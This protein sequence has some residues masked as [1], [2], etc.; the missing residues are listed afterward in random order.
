MALLCATLEGDSH[1]SCVTAAH[2]LCLQ[3]LLGVGE[4]S[5]DHVNVYAAE[6]ENKLTHASRHFGHQ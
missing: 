6:M 4:R 2:A 3:V 5:C 1:G